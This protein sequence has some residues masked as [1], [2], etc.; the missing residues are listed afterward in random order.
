MITLFSAP[1]YCGT[2]ANKGAILKITNNEMKVIQY[3]FTP[4][5][6]I[7]LH[8]GDAFTWSVPLISKALMDMFV[9]FLSY[10]ND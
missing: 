4:K 8:L 5:P 3:N 10:T 6:D 2:Y 1:N 7:L 9:G